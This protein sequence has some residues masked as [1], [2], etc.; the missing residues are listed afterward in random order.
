MTQKKMGELFVSRWLEHQTE[1]ICETL[2]FHL[3][4]LKPNC[5]R[6]KNPPAEPQQSCPSD[7]LFHIN[8]KMNQQAEKCISYQHCCYFYCL[9]WFKLYSCSEYSTCYLL[10]NADRDSAKATWEHFHT[11]FSCLC[12]QMYLYEPAKYFDGLNTCDK[13]INKSI[14]KI[15]IGFVSQMA[16]KIICWTGWGNLLGLSWLKQIWLK[17]LCN[18]NTV[19]R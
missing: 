14:I 4:S 18:A 19:K 12:C 9:K 6:D 10:R 17:Q 7:V 1:S 3:T 13:R 2:L 16:A 11:L 8:W 5:L 15:C